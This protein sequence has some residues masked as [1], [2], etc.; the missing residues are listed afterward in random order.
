[1][2][3]EITD[4]LALSPTPFSAGL[5]V[6]SREDGTP[7]SASYQ[8]WAY[9]A[10]V[11][12]DQDFAG[13][14]ELQKTQT[15]QKLRYMGQTPLRP[16]LYL[17][18]RIRIKAISGNFPSVRI[19]GWAGNAAGSH[20]SGLIEAGPA[21]TLSSYG[22]V[23]EV[24]AIV[25]AGN[26]TGVDMVWG[27]TPVFGHFGLDLTGSNGGIVRIDDVVIEDATD[28]FARKLMDW[29]DVRDYGAKGDGVTNDAAAFE[30]ADTAAAGRSVLVSAGSYYLGSNVT[31]ESDVRFEGT[32]TMPAGARLSLT[33]NYDL[34]SY[35]A[36]FGTEIEGFRRALQALFAFT[37]HSVLDLAGRRIELDAP[38]DVAAI[39]GQTGLAYASR[40][41]LANGQINVVSGAG[42]TTGST[43]SQATY[44][45]GQPRTLTA[46]ANVAQIE[47]GA[48]VTGTGVG[49]EVY[50]RSK[51]VS[52]GTVTL[53]QPLWGAAGTRTFTFRRFRY[54]LDFSGFGAL[55]K[56]EIRNVEFLLNGLSSG[57]MLAPDGLTF[58]LADSV[59]NKPLDRGI[60]SIG[61]GCQGMLVDTCQFLSNEQQLATQDRSSIVLNVNAND[62]K[63]RHNRAVRFAHFAVLTGTGNMLIG[64]HFFHGDNESQ[65]LR[66]GGVVLTQT[67]AKTTIT[68]NYIDNC[69]IE[70]TNEHDVAPD[71]SSGYSFGGLT[72]TGNIFTVNDVSAAH[73]WFV[74]KPFGSGHYL[75]GLTLSNNTFRT[76]NG[77]IDRVDQVDTTYADLDYSRF[78]NVTVAGNSFNGVNQV[79]ANPV[80]LQFTQNTAAGSWTLD[81][82]GYLPFGGWARNV[83]ALTAEGMITGSAGERRTDMPYFTTMQGSLKRE[84]KV[85]W[86]AAS[87]GTVLIGLRCDNPA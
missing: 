47:V 5:D 25:G 65:G 81:S 34:A 33:R 9:A 22:E 23:V 18:I 48:L 36:A 85:N 75:H 38:I 57:I 21:V 15:T 40:R 3:I 45:T 76:L 55:D 72:V 20:V 82:G 67:N 27:T 87:K 74:V 64:N 46:V 71:F 66:R 73:R 53:S 59:M 68:G 44:A 86:S 2:N 29:V 63:I 49:R 78:R 39:A 42:W 69:Y 28:V 80:T 83:V 41:V 13:C 43:T 30:A 60:T 10:Y 37:D 7:G 50:V 62:P 77:N 12:A 8:G 52:A 35:E 19:A 26:R 61:E 17:R 54:A 51:N 79:I 1:M 14:L 6:W 32:V 70:W 11:A 16:G 58:V 24:S 4:G 31:F 84:V 56:F